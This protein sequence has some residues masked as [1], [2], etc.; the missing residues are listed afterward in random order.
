MARTARTRNESDETVSTAF[1]EGA[2]EGTGTRGTRGSRRGFGVLNKANQ[3]TFRVG[4]DSEVIVFLEP[5]NFTYAMRHWVRYLDD[6]GQQQTRVEYCLED[7]CPLCDIGDRPKA[8]AFFNVVDLTI[9]TKVLVWEATADPTAAIQKEF[10]KLA[11][12]KQNLSDDGLYWVVSREK[13][14]N[15]FYSYSV[16]KL[17]EEDLLAEWPSLKPLSPAQRAALRARAYDEDYVQLKERDELAE[18]VDT[19]G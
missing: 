7:D 4:D 11:K 17:T 15:G 12:R 13:K 5:E 2:N 9:P 16:D 8:T 18:F 19:L 1:D 3:T 10:N 14:S 6:S